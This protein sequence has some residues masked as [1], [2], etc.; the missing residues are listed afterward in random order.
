M[1]RHAIVILLLAAWSAGC[2]EKAAVSPPMRYAAAVVHVDAGSGSAR[3]PVSR[4]YGVNPNG[5][6]TGYG[7]RFSIEDR[8]EVKYDFIGRGEYAVADTNPREWGDGDVY[9]FSIMIGPETVVK[10]VVFQGER[11]SI[12]ERDE[13][14]VT[15]EPANQQVHRTP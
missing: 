6:R 14:R 1:K 8:I 2:R 10:P 12:Y 4:N 11:L 13:F 5:E 7:Q 9:L 3:S 15:M